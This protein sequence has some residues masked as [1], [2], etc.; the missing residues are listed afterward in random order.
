MTRPQK[1]S[2]SSKSRGYDRSHY[3]RPHQSGRSPAQTR[4]N[5]KRHAWNASFLV[6]G[7]G[8]VRAG[9]KLGSG[10]RRFHKAG[11]T[12]MTRKLAGKAWRGSRR[13]IHKVRHPLRNWNPIVRLDRRLPFYRARLA[14]RA[15]I[16][17]AK[18]AA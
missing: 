7:Y 11:G 9:W 12:Y 13:V 5:F 17:L 3:Y 18:D 16:D 1:K 4:A 6:P 8:A 2:P 15:A 10:I 14:R